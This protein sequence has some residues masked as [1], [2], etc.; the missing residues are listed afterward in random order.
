ML[1]QR[2]RGGRGILPNYSNPGTKSTQM[3]S[4]T[5]LPLYPLEKLGT[6]CTGDLM[7]LGAEL[8]DRKDLCRIRI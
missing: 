4:T 8:D 5:L 1:I 3:V 2:Q 6:F 7:G